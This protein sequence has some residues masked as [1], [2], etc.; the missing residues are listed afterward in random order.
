MSLDAFESRFSVLDDIPENLFADIITHTHGELL[1]RARGILQWRAALLE[2]RLPE[3]GELCWPEEKLRR[4]ILMRLEVLD[5]V[6]YCRDEPELT[7]SILETILEGV[8][9]AEDYFR[10]A[11]DFDD[12]IAQQQKIRDRD[13]EFEDDEGIANHVDG[14]SDGGGGDRGA[15]EGGAAASEQGGTQQQA[16]AGDDS[17]DNGQAAGAQADM[18][19]DAVEAGDDEPSAEM[20][21]G[22]GAPSPGADVD[23]A[24]P[25][26]DAAVEAESLMQGASPDPLGDELDR[27]WGE[28][29]LSWRELAGVLDELGARLG[30]GWD[31]TQGI[32]S[33]QGWRDIARYRRL[34]EDLPE[35]TRLVA[36]LGRMQESRDEDG[37][38]SVAEAI[39][40]PLRREPDETPRKLAE[41]AVA[42]TEGV[43]LSD[44]IA[45][46]LPVESALLGHDVLNTLWHARRAESMLRCY[47][48]QDVL[49]QHT[50]EPDPEPERQGSDDKGKDPG[51]GPIIVCLDSSAS[52]AGE[53]ETIA[54]AVTLEAL[55][56]AAAEDRDCLVIAFSGEEQM[57]RWE[58]PAGRRFYRDLLE[59]LR[60]SYHGGTDVVSALRAALDEI[61]TA[62]WNRADILLISDGRFPLPE[63]VLPRIEKARDEHGLRVHGLLVGRWRGQVMEQVCDPL[64]RYDLWR[65]KG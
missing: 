23:E 38:R 14:G 41:H 12:R 1:T 45:R 6:R 52:M 3:I 43:K 48:L 44:D 47:Q 25:E 58:M 19:G 2:G 50:P 65:G 56:I 29:S 32:L 49:S 31:L 8:A 46:M 15:G 24:P 35:L 60:Q 4:T 18:E 39:A 63:E 61:E 64:H 30:R 42:T 11:G 13:S 55:R 21:A 16:L 10:K 27:Q 34:M 54:K 17:A 36:I 22:G 59:F 37:E 28:L 57:M 51:H 40:D 53:P 20:P 7:D 33:S 26:T 5:I 9:S 62:D